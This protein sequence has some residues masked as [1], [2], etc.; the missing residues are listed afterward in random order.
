MR[1]D[2]ISP[3]IIGIP[4]SGSNFFGREEQIKQFFNMLNSRTLQ[5]MRVM[6]L[7]RSGKTSFLRHVSTCNQAGKLLNRKNQ[8]TVIAYVD[9]HKGISGINE[10][11]EAI[12]RAIHKVIPSDCKPPTIVEGFKTFSSWLENLFD[13][14]LRCVVLLDEY[15]V[16]TN[17]THPEFDASFFQNLRAICCGDLL[18]YFTWT[19]CSNFELSDVS[20]QQRMQDKSSPF[21][22][23]FHNPIIIGGLAQKEA[24]ELINKPIEKCGIIHTPD[25]ISMIKEIAGSIPYFVQAVAHELFLIKKSGTSTKHLSK[26]IMDALLYPKSNIDKLFRNY[27]GNFTRNERKFLSEIFRG[28]PYKRSGIHYEKKLL[29]YGLLKEDGESLYPNGIL[30]KQWFNNDQQIPGEKT[31]NYTTFHHLITRIE[32]IKESMNE[33]K[34]RVLNIRTARAKLNKI[35]QII[36]YQNLTEQIKEMEETINDIENE[37]YKNRN[38][39]L[40]LT[41]GDNNFLELADKIKDRLPQLSEEQINTLF[42]YIVELQAAIQSADLQTPPFFIRNQ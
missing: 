13:K 5:P 12:I 41:L 14:N 40:S 26:T 38:K 17:V 3:Y 37:V 42:P 23:I 18:S 32:E 1:P 7:R 31:V 30:F 9:L 28:K 35:T 11:Y 15:E 6:G 29:D 19:I 36:E 8:R 27:W 10:F 24:N 2:I 16:L 39:L 33:L 34:S 20:T 22:N 25:E 4:V 21:D